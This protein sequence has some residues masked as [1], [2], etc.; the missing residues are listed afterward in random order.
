MNLKFESTSGPIVTKV[1]AFLFFMFFHFLALVSV[2]VVL[3][4]F[5]KYILLEFYRQEVFRQ[6]LCQKRLRFCTFLSLFPHSSFPSTNKFLDVTSHPVATYNGTNILDII[7]LNRGPFMSDCNFA[8]S[9]WC[10]ICR[11][12]HYISIFSIN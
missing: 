6:E 10:C 4:L 12:H 3:T 11:H 5:N 9:Y 7:Y 2:K 8:I 1:W